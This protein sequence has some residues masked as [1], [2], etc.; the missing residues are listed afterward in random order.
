[1][2]VFPVIPALREAFSIQSF[3]TRHTPRRPFQA[4]L[5]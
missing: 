3:A 2:R 5:A 1:M 4:L